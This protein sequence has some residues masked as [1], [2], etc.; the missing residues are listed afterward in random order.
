MYGSVGEAVVSGV[1][2]HIDESSAF[3]PSG[4]ELAEFFKSRG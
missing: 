2:A 4:G 3:R 1:T